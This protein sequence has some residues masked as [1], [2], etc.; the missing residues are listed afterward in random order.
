MSW[1]RDS[2]C[3]SVFW[4]DST[5][6]FSCWPTGMH[7]N[8]RTP[9]WSLFSGGDYICSGPLSTCFQEAESILNGL[10]GM[11]TSLPGLTLAG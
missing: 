6:G 5:G 7:E 9:I 1:H 10:D 11:E 4:V 8:Q 2:N 3:Y